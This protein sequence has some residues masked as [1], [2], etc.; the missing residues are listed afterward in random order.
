MRTC[1][2]VPAD[3]LLKPLC[4]KTV[5]IRGRNGDSATFYLGV[6]DL[7]LQVHNWTK[8]FPKQNYLRI[9][10]SLSVFLSGKESELGD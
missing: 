9:V 4:M 2:L 8:N 10:F 5:C 3:K 7:G 1:V 6:R